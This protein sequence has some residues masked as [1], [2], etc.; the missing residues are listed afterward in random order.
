MEK[1]F[2]LVALNTPFNNSIL[3]YE[4]TSIFSGVELGK[5]ILVPLGKREVI[6]CI[7]EKD[8]VDLKGIEAKRV[9]PAIELVEDYFSLEKEDINQDGNSLKAE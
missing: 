4:T 5:F 3:A 7:V 2:S 9:K 6:G 8:L 1:K